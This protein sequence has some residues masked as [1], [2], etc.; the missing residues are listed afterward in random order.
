MKNEGG[1]VA[2]DGTYYAVVKGTGRRWMVVDKFSGA[3]ID[4]GTRSCA[5]MFAS[6]INQNK[7]RREGGR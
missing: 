1:A 7:V 6:A 4:E 2:F 3:V 5:V